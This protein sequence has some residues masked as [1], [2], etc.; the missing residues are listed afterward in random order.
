MM[1]YSGLSSLTLSLS[2]FS[3]RQNGKSFKCCQMWPKHKKEFCLGKAY[4]KVPPL[5]GIYILQN[6][7]AAGG[8]AAGEK[9]KK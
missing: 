4:K 8:M 5:A 2:F 3:S 6:T 1:N 7:M 9:N